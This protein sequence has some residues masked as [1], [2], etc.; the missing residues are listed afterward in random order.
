MLRENEPANASETY[1]RL[2]DGQKVRQR[3]SRKPFWKRMQWSCEPGV[4]HLHS[5]AQ[6]AFMELQ[7]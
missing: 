1:L 6:L 4:S 7:R 3:P 2:E 5:C